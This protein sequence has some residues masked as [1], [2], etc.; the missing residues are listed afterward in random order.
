MEVVEALIRY[1]ILIGSDNDSILSKLHGLNFIEDESQYDVFLERIFEARRDVCSH[2]AYDLFGQGVPKDDVVQRLS[3][4]CKFLPQPIVESIL[5]KTFKS[6][7]KKKPKSSIKTLESMVESLS[8]AGFFIFLNY[9]GYFLSI[10]TY[11]DRTLPAYYDLTITIERYNDEQRLLLTSFLESLSSKSIRVF[12]N[13]LMETLERF[14]DL[15][16]KLDVLSIVMSYIEEDAVKLL[17][18]GLSKSKVIDYLREKYSDVIDHVIKTQVTLSPIDRELHRLFSSQRIKNRELSSLIYGGVLQIARNRFKIET[19]KYILP[20]FSLE[21]TLIAWSKHS[22][23]LILKLL[24]AINNEGLLSLR[25]FLENW[26]R[27][28]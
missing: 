24:N 10:K 20:Q 15:H 11:G 17:N 1:L 16:A 23:N 9:S 25:S 12:T 22:R 4:M 2:I 8:E 13:S 21:I 18:K 19:P 6:A 27:G 28:K 14:G 5:D 26:L 3:P 7:S